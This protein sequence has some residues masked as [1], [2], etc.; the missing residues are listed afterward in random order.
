[1]TVEPKKVLYSSQ[2]SSLINLDLLMRG[3]HRN[4][5]MLDVAWTHSGDRLDYRVKV[6]LKVLYIQE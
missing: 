2:P 1:M 3:R 4:F 6:E 5:K